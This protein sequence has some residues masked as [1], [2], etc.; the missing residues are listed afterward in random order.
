MSLETELVARFLSGLGNGTAAALL[1]PDAGFQALNVNLAGKDAVLE[2]LARS[3]AAEARWT[4]ED[5]GDAVQA[6]GTLP[7]G[8]RLVLTV[9]VKDG[10]IALL[11][12][13]MLPGA[14]RP[15]SELRLSPDI[16]ERIN[17]AL[18]DRHPILISYVDED[19]QPN[20]T[21][22]GSTQAFSDDQLAIWVRNEGGKMLRS[23]RKNP[24][25][26]LMYRDEESKATYIFQGRARID[27]SEAA[28]KKIY[29]TMAQVERDHDFAHLGVA[30][31][32][33][34][35]LVEGYGGLSPQGPVNPVRMARAK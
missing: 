34:L 2:R 32:I 7:N 3:P 33:D 21:F 14:P 6:V 24:K 26:A 5:K 4:Q 1:A 10:R 15:P 19:G 9:R 23:I 29:D 11:Q 8:A 27:A 17:N 12:Q 31:V 30:L 20:V 28:R 13:Q 18:K 25:V 35:D 22:R 16:K